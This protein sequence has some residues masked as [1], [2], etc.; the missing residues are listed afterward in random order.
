[1]T[2]LLYLNINMAGWLAAW[3]NRSP[4]SLHI[5]AGRALGAFNHYAVGRDGD[6][7]SPSPSRALKL[8]TEHHMA[9]SNGGHYSRR[10]RAEDSR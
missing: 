8:S 10:G 3:L 2:W 4:A 9:A 5:T 7:T 6:N 1:M